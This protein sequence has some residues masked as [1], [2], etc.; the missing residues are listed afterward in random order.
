MRSWVITR[1]SGRVQS[2]NYLG[3]T[4]ADT[5]AVT[6]TK[7]LSKS[8]VPLIVSEKKEVNKNRD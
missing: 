4:K 7:C 3:R 2:I 5:S 1:Q 8:N 6:S